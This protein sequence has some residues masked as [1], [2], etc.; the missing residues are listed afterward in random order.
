MCEKFEIIDDIIFDFVSIVFKFMKGVSYW[1]W[2]I[3][4]F[5][6]ILCD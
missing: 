2:F 6:E 3:W 5:E 4:I 1:F